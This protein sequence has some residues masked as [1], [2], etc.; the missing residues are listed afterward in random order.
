MYFEA[1]LGLSKVVLKGCT[2]QKFF[3]LPFIPKDPKVIG[4]GSRESHASI[5]LGVES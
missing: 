5:N 4:S 2:G 3:F 1:C